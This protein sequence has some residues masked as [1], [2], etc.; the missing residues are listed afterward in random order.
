MKTNIKVF[1]AAGLMALTASCTDLD[2]KPEAQFT[3]YPTV[4]I[5]SHRHC[6]QMSG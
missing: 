5:W 3:E 4:V 2:V 6:L 1:F